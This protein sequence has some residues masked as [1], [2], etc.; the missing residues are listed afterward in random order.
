MSSIL[1][2]INNFVPFVP[3]GWRQLPVPHEVEHEEQ[4]DD[5]E[6]FDEIVGRHR[7]IFTNF[8]T[9]CNQMSVSFTT[10]YIFHLQIFSV[11]EIFSV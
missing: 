11:F 4:F 10:E 2:V 6:K 1:N 5:A 3:D 8:L 7:D 9:V